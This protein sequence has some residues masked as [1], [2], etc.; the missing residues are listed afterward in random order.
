MAPQTES[1][2]GMYFSGRAVSSVSGVGDH[3]D[4][5]AVAVDDDDLVALLQEVDDG[6][7]R[8]LDRDR[9]LGQILAEG[10]AA[11]GD[12]D[13]FA[14]RSLLKLMMAKAPRKTAQFS[15]TPRRFPR[16]AQALKQNGSNAEFRPGTSAGRALLEP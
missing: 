5:R 12:D 15:G 4:L 1:G 3:A 9:L 11:Q 6:A 8:V 7:S 13:S 10:V 14:A 16:K 2:H